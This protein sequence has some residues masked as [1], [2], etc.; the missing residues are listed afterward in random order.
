MKPKTS[1][2]PTRRLP[3]R[4]IVPME[5]LDGLRECFRTVTALASLLEASGAG[6]QVEMLRAD[7]VSHTGGLILVEMEKTGALL[8]QLESLR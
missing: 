3:A 2:E 6:P 8:K 4:R 1:K 7:V 5:C